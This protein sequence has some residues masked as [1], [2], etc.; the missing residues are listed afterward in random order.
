MDPVNG[1]ARTVAAALGVLILL[2]LLGILAVSAGVVEL[3]LDAWDHAGSAVSLVGDTVAV[4]GLLRGR[5]WGWWLAVALVALDVVLLPVLELRRGATDLTTVT[6][7]GLTLLV[8]AGILA[9]LDRP[10]TRDDCGIGATPR[11][12]VKPLAIVGVM[13]GVVPLLS[14]PSGF[15]A[16]AVFVLIVWLRRRRRAQ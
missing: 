4:I 9:L 5:R 15:A 1:G 8:D 13:L 6:A 2:E 7:L 11:L 16:V 12:P 3:P 10:R 14:T